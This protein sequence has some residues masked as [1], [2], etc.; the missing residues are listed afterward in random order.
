MAAKRYRRRKF[1]KTGPTAGI[2]AKARNVF[3]R[4]TKEVLGFAVF[5]FGAYLGFTLTVSGQESWTIWLA[6]RMAWPLVFSL[7]VTGAVMMLG[8][9]SGYCR[10][11]APAAGA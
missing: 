7:V 8:H 10:T 4:H 6:G 5:L 3:S 9:R 1:Q 2:Q 11:G